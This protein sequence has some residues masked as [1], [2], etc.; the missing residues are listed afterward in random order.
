MADFCPTSPGTVLWRPTEGEIASSNLTRFVNYLNST[1]AA[2]LC[3]GDYDGLHAWSISNLGKFWAAVAT[4]TG[5]LPSQHNVDLNNVVVSGRDR[6]LPKLVDVSWF[7]GARLNFAKIALRY[8][9]LN[10]Q[11]T[12]ISYR[13]ESRTDDVGYQ[14]H[15]SF[16]ALEARVLKL[17][18][19]LRRAGVRRGDAIAGVLA[20]TPDAVIAMLATAAVGAIWSCCAPDFGQTAVCER[21]RQT[22]PKVLFYSPAYRYKGKV[23]S[24]V[25]NINGIVQRLPTLELVLC[26]PGGCPPGSVVRPQ[27]AANIENATHVLLRDFEAAVGNAEEFLYEIVTMNDPVVTMFSSGTTGR[28]KCIVQGSGIL[29]NQL[30]EHSLHHEITD[31]SV[32]L[33]NTST[34]WMLFNWLLAALAT[35]CTIVLYDGAA[36]PQDDPYR[37]ITIGR[38]EG[39]THFGS[40]AKYFQALKSVHSSKVKG[41][42]PGRAGRAPIPT[43]RMVMGTGSPS[44]EEHFLFVQ[45]FFGVHV[46]YSS[47]SGGT[48]INGC[49]ALG[50]PWKPVVIS[51]LQCAGLGMDVHVLDNNGRAVVGQSGELVCLNPCPCM[52]LCFGHDDG[53]KRYR[54][55]YFLKFGESIWNHGDFAVETSGGGFVISG[56]SDS[57]LNPGGVRI[58]TSDIYQV[59]ECIRYVQE[60]LVTEQPVPGDSRVI[61]FVVMEDGTRLDHRKEM[62]IRNSLNSRLSP[63]HVPH[64]IIQVPEIPYTFSGKKCEIP[65]KKILQGKEADNK[66]AVKNPTAF[67]AIRMAI[68]KKGLIRTRPM[69]RSLPSCKM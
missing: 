64:S 1:F 62:E 36:V 56:R 37:L 30:K 54:S 58:G 60:A 11:R 51:E 40:G 42:R 14:R 10:G 5:F 69:Q 55:S 7:P 20:N 8:S 43:L 29:L 66:E 12:A 38:E 67:D 47:M 28:P 9:A 23:R 34:G 53:H 44:T 21:F 18:S 59:V 4:F 39:V 13:P 33:Y 50:S 46:Q 25:S 68:Q 45:S 22:N 48:E 3:V 65:V 57:T 6:A 41:A 63:R 19:A 32:M 35:G 26:V 61:M 52:P 15:I 16:A 31:K 24:V 2:H 17:A 49:F 27:M